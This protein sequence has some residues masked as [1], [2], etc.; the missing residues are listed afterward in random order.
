MKKMEVIEG[1]G[2]GGSCFVIG[3]TLTLGLAGVNPAS[4]WAAWQ[5][6]DAIAYCWNT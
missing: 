4:Y 2:A 3:L 1:E 6:R 5:G